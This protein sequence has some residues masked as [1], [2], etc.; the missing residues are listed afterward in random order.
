MLNTKKGEYQMKTCTI[1]GDQSSD[2][3][4]ENY[5]TVQICDDCAEADEILREDAKIVSEGKYDPYFGDT[6][7]FCGKAHE[8]EAQES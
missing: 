6:C 7:E 1:Y 5:P 2:R 4:S 3:A 8:E